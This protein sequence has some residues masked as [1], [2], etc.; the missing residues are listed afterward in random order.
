MNCKANEMMT[1]STKLKQAMLLVIIANL[2]IVTIKLIR[3]S[4]RIFEV[5]ISQDIY[6]SVNS[7]I[8][9]CIKKH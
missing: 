6:W 7:E 4:A 3:L 1:F 2:K 5:C 9:N 8:G